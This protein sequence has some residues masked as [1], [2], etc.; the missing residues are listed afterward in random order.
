MMQTM[1]DIRVDA[2]DDFEGVSKIVEAFVRHQWDE[3]QSDRTALTMEMYKI[4]ADDEGSYRITWR[5]VDSAQYGWRDVM[6]GPPLDEFM[7]DDVNDVD[8]AAYGLAEMA[9]EFLEVTI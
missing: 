4:C 2:V 7:A 8:T 6:M 9:V 1:P 3:Y 5:D